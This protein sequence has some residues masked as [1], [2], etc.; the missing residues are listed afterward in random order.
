[1]KIAVIG[2]SGHIGTW[3]SPR[4]A[5]AGHE[6]VCVSR[7]LRQPYAPHKAWEAVARITLDRQQEEAA[8]MFASRIAAIAAEVVIDLTCY[9]P[10]SARH[11]AEGLHGKVA[12]VLHCGTIWVHGH[13][14][15]RPI[16]EDAPRHPFGDYGVRKAAIEK[17][18]LTESGLPATVLHAGH[19]VGP[20][21]NP[22]NPAGNSNPKVFSDLAAG[23]EVLLPNLGME[24]LHHVHAAD[25]AQ[26]FHLAVENR[27]AAIGEAFHVVS[28]AAV[29]MRGYSEEVARWSGR[30]AN[31]RFLPY[32]EWRSHFSERDAAVTRD[33]IDHSPNCSIDKAR[34]RLGYNPRF[35]SLDAV[36]EAIAYLFPR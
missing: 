3:L 36:R 12:H 11:L 21:W 8:G 28:P 32:E 25:V 7:G 13:V 4:L 33:H 16:T 6:V 31:L 22:I 14:V 34:S 17:Y 1:L 10:K 18:L 24:T 20:G 19:L 23:R 30:E 9:T 35:R 2:G 27:A 29:T 5:E 15:E 26:A